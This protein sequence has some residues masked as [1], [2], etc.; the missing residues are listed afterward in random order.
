MSL[1]R[2]GTQ[3]RVRRVPVLDVEFGFA[4]T[5]TLQLKLTWRS[6]ARRSYLAILHVLCMISRMHKRLEERRNFDAVVLRIFLSTCKCALFVIVLP[7]V[8]LSFGV[9]K[10]R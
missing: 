9:P 7:P 10:V 5:L 2:Y 3:I 4:I 8:K 6:K 1:E